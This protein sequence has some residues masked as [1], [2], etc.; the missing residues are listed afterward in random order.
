VR[1]EQVRGTLS[2]A[3][4]PRKSADADDDEPQELG[5]SMSNTKDELID[6]AE[7]LGL[8]VSASMT[9]AEILTAI[10]EEADAD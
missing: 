9:K 2:T 8:D 3:D 10:E 6:I 1:G 4:L 5:A 7:S